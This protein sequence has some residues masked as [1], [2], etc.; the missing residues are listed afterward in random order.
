MS[1]SESLSVVSNSLWP[2]G[3]HSPWNSPGRNTG[4]GSLSLLQEIFPTQGTNPGLLHCRRILYQLNHKGSP[5]KLKWVAYPF[6]S[7]SSPPKNQT[8]VSCIASGFFTNWAIREAQIVSKDGVNKSYIKTKNLYFSK[9]DQVRSV[10]QSCHSGQSLK[11]MSFELVMPSRHLILC[12]PLL[13]LP[14]ILPSIRVFSNESALHITWPKYQS[15]SF[16]ISPS[17][18]HP[19]LIS[20]RMDG[21]ISLQSKKLSRVLQYHSSK[22]SV[23]LHSAFFTIQLSHPYITTGKKPYEWYVSLK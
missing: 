4:V 20:F 15:F 19:E 22:A 11:P 10:T 1:Q 8:R 14:P 6:S 16:S 17:N 21:W 23:F 7:G 18:D 2:Q 9:T 12:H 13:L 3:L 5:R